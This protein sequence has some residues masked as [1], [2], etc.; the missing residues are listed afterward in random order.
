[1]DLLADI[2]ILFNKV[3]SKNPKNGGKLIKITNIDREIL[4]IF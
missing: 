1:M 4:H 3:I 2:I